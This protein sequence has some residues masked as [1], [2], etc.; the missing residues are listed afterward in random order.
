MAPPPVL[1]QLILCSNLNF[2]IAATESP[3]PTS[4]KAPCAVA[5]PTAIATSLR[6]ARARSYQRLQTIS[7]QGSHHRSDIGHRAL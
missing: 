2:L 5:F 6:E 3:P 7:L 4:E 1:I